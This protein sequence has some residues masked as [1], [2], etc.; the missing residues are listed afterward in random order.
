M[1]STSTYIIRLGPIAATTSPI[2]N[3]SARSDYISNWVARSEATY[4]FSGD[5]ASQ[6]PAYSCHPHISRAMSNCTKVNITFS[7]MIYL[8]NLPTPEVP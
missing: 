2:S 4:L 6:A 8:S 3:F 7:S 1:P 5:A